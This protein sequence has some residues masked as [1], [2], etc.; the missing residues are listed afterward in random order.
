[1]LALLAGL[2]ILFEWI[3]VATGSVDYTQH[4]FGT[5]VFEAKGGW[6]YRSRHDYVLSTHIEG[7]PLL[8]G[9]TTLIFTVMRRSMSL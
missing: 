1:M 8:T 3:F 9:G 6:A 2:V 4:H 5:E 7:T